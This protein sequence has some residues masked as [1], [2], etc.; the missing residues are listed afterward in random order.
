MSVEPPE[1]CKP[2]SRM[3]EAVALDAEE[4]V[5][6]LL[7]TAVGDYAEEALVLP[8]VRSGHWLPQL[9]AAD[10]IKVTGGPNSGDQKHPTPQGVGMPGELLAPQVGWPHF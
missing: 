7:R 6:A 9:A 5:V 3:S 8:S 10:Y 4:L 1:L 2:Q